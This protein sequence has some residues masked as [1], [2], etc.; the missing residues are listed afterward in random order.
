MEQW[1]LNKIHSKNIPVKDEAG[2]FWE[3]RGDRFHCGVDLYAPEGSEVASIEDCVIVEVG[4]MT[5]PSI[6]PYWNTTYY[7]VT[8]NDSG[9][10]FKYGELSKASVQE[11]D[12]ISSGQLIGYVGAV[13]NPQK[14]D[15]T[16]PLYIQKLKNNNTSMLHFEVWKD[17]PITSHEDY[18]GGN[19]FAKERPVN[20]IDPTEYLKSVR[21]KVFKEHTSSEE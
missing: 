15:G 21:D 8:K 5:S 16:S 4:M 17:E 20:L 12:R 9:I 14:I 2:C 1:P 10:F 3:N 13:L 7:V 19:W 11:G 6:L 18:L